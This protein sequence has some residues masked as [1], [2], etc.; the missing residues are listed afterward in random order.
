MTVDACKQLGAFCSKFLFGTCL[1]IGS[2][3]RADSRQAAN[4][5]IPAE[6]PMVKATQV[7]GRAGIALLRVPENPC[8]SRL[9]SECVLIAHLGAFCSEF[10]FGSLIT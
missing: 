5:T 7:C 3:R 9:Q 10:L 8:S 6:A 2:E 1:G 4:A